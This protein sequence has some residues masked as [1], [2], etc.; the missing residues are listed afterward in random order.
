MPSRLDTSG[1]NELCV[2]VC[3]CVW[4]T[5]FEKCKEKKE[6]HDS[7]SVLQKQDGCSVSPKKQ[8]LD[9]PYR[10][11]LLLFTMG[12]V[13]FHGFVLVLRGSRMNST[14]EISV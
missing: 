4:T 8:G 9:R 1:R 2:C 5:A 11:R 14:P 13:G 6:M 12:F 7:K 10:V 3:V